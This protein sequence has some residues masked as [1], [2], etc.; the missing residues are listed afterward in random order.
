MKK[1]LFILAIILLFASASFAYESYNYNQLSNNPLALTIEYEDHF[2]LQKNS[3]YDSYFTIKTNKPYATINIETIE[4]N[5]VNI[6]PMQKE[7][8]IANANSETK[9]LYKINTNNANLTKATPQFI[10]NFSDYEGN[11]NTQRFVIFVDVKE[12]NSE[13]YYTTS[14]TNTP[15]EIKINYF[16]KFITMSKNQEKITEIKLTNKGSYA[17]FELEY[18]NNK[19][20]EIE[21][22]TPKQ[23]N[24]E[25]NQEKTLRLKIKSK[26]IKEDTYH[27]NLALR[28]TGSTKTYDIGLMAINIKEYE[29]KTTTTNTTI[30][31]GTNKETEPPDTNKTD[32]NSFFIIPQIDST[33]FSFLG[34]DFA[35]G[36]IILVLLVLGY[37]IFQS[38]NQTFRVDSLGHVKEEPKPKEEKKVSPEIQEEKETQEEAKEI[39]K[40]LNDELEI[41]NKELPETDETK[42]KLNQEIEDKIKY[43]QDHAKAKTQA[44]V[45][46]KPL[47]KP[48]EKS[49]KKKT[50]TKN[51]SKSKK[52]II[53]KPAKPKYKGKKNNSSFYPLFLTFQAIITISLNTI[54]SLYN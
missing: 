52:K 30:N 17:Q 19:N 29:I 42:E 23:I 25:K 43:F 46:N 33:A 47:R 38:K 31:T 49:I 5:G 8:Y 16:E 41:L 51:S 26:D 39:I 20:F 12:E 7:Y 3:I 13:I 44:K 15:P 28:K 37:I 2:E 35:L 40:E 32:S 18:T 27:I 45:N 11:K 22:L 54:L 53:K 36:G 24:L 10:I 21:E 1:I 34:N 48:V 9:I 4:D 14:N 50:I 6:E